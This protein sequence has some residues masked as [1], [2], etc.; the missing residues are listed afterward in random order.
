MANLPTVKVGNAK[1]LMNHTMPSHKIS[2][3][4]PSIAGF[5]I[6]AETILFNL[7]NHPCVTVTVAGLNC[8]YFSSFLP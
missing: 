3:S 5:R 8:F 2:E 1:L 6:M 4:E 7:G